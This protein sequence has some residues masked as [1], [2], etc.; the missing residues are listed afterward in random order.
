MVGGRHRLAGQSGRVVRRGQDAR[1]L[2][3]Q[4]ARLC[5]YPEPAEPADEGHDGPPRHRAADRDHAAHAD[6]PP[7][8]GA[9]DPADRP[10]PDGQQRGCA[11][12]PPVRAGTA[13]P[14]RRRGPPDLQYPVRGFRSETGP[15]RRPVAAPDLRR[16]E[17]RRQPARYRADAAVRR[18]PD[19]RLREAA[20]RL[21]GPGGGV[22]PG[23]CR[24]TAL[25]GHRQRPAPD[26]G[27]RPPPAR[28]PASGRHL[29][30]RPA[31]DAACR[32]A[33]DPGRV[34][35]RR[36]QPPPRRPVPPASGSS[37]CA[38]S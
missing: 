7:Q 28:E 38:S 8:H 36:R 5:R 24:G 34:R 21:G 22:P 10:G 6:F 30:A 25:Q 13:H 37:S 4:R 9:A 17:C 20:A 23:Q 3:F 11:R 33:R 19:R 14:V 29:A 27:I 26:G 2:C 32:H 16:A 31:Q 1:R 12:I 18:Y 15:F 35:T